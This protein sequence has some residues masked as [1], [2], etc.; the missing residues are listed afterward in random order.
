MSLLEIREAIAIKPCE[1]DLRIGQLVN[2]IDQ[3]VPWCGNLLVL[4]EEEHLIH[5]AHHTVKQYLTASS[6]DALIDRFHF[7]IDEADHHAGE[8]CCTYL[9]FN[10]FDRRL[11]RIPNAK[12]RVSLQPKLIL[13]SSLAT[14]DSPAI[15]RSWSKFDHLLK[16]KRRKDSA[17]T[18]RYSTHLSLGGSSNVL[19]NLQTQNPLLAYA[20]EFWLSHTTH[21]DTDRTRAWSLWADLVSTERPFVSRPWTD[22]EFNGVQENVKQFILDHEHAALLALLVR[23]Q[24]DRAVSTLEKRRSS[25]THSWPIVL[26][27]LVLSTAN[28]GSL[29]LF[30]ILY[31][32]KRRNL[33]SWPYNDPIES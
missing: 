28:K 12:A 13:Q 19:Q 24:K 22:D 33:Q 10:A 29:L 20:S 5:F 7:Q 27:D 23:I 9:S 3:M 2:D 31:L 32:E 21:F 26:D 4:D 18:W 1:K 17:D 30:R 6:S 15:A 11:A 25:K 14:G 8:I 16:S